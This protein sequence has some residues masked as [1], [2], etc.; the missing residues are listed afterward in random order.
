MGRLICFGLHLPL[1]WLSVRGGLLVY[2]LALPQ[3]GRINW[4]A[5]WILLSLSLSLWQAS[6]WPQAASCLGKNSIKF[7]TLVSGS[8]LLLLC[9]PENH[10]LW[11]VCGALP[12]RCSPNPVA[13]CSPLART[14]THT[15][16]GLSS[17]NRLQ[18]AELCPQCNSGPNL[19][20]AHPDLV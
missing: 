9:S 15:H 13:Q 2:L 18:Q 8:L 10:E 16:G 19:P 6:L 14:Q 11:R 17:A 7:A 12:S 1:C 4:D 20:L 5:F 3:S